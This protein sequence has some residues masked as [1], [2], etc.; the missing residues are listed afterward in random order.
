MMLIYKNSLLYFGHFITFFWWSIGKKYQGTNFF[1]ERD[2]KSL[3]KNMVTATL[4]AFDF[5]QILWRVV[6]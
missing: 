1:F 5:V 3:E 4:L 6:I 2:K